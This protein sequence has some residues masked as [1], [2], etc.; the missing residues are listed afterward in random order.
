VDPL[1]LVEHD[2]FRVKETADR[3]GII[4]NGALK[5]IVKASEVTANDLELIYQG[6]V[7]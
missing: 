6:V 2:L 5:K 7:E 4:K 3:V 1:N